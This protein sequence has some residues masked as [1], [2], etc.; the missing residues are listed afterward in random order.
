MTTMS[1]PLLM[2]SIHPIYLLRRAGRDFSVAM[3]DNDAADVFVYTG[4]GEGAVVPKDAVRV[5]IDPSV[6]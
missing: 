5:R 1:M 4:V 6:R 3:A 2:S